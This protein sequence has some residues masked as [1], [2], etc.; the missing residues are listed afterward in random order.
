MIT[1]VGKH[2]YFVSHYHARTAR[3]NKPLEL[4][5][6]RVERDRADFEGWFPF[7]CIPDLQGGAAQRQA[8][9]LDDNSFDLGGTSIGLVRLQSLLREAL[10]REMPVATLFRF[11]TLH[12]QAAY[13]KDPPANRNK[14]AAR[15]RRITE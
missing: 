5:P 1:P 14:L 12:A 13:L 9:G 3:P 6:L 7:N 10:G 8:V 2:R 11:P 4:T 15:Q